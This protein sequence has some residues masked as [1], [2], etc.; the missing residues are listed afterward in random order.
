MLT[1][2]R[3]Q[4]LIEASHENWRQG[5]L[6]GLLDQY[7]GDMEYWCNAGDPAGGPIEFKGKPAFQDSLAAILRTT[8]CTSRILTFDFDGTRAKINAWYRLERTG[9][10]IVLEG[11]YRQIVSYDRGLISRLEEFHDAGRLTAFWQLS[12]GGAAK[13]A[14]W[15]ADEIKPPISHVLDK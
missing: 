5:N 14:V 2:D 3:A 15:D 7:T 4:E 10:A 12:S 6:N 8:R 9:T 1:Y 11:T 13:A